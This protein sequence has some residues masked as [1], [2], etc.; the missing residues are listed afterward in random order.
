[1]YPGLL[2]TMIGLVI[3]G[4]WLTAMLSRLCGRVLNGA[5]PLLA[6][7]RLADDPKLAF[8]AMRGLVL[9]V[10]LGTIVGALVPTLDS[11]VATPNAGSLSN[12]LVDDLAG[13]WA[14]MPPARRP[15]PRW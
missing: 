5:S 12:V 7:R 3:A 1:M 8:R 11:L 13:P 10:F 6:T 2:V 4:P 15:V 14:R 9:A